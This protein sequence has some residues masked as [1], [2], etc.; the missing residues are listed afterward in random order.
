M[1]ELRLMIKSY[2]AQCANENLDLS[3]EF[4]QLYVIKYEVDEGKA[5]AVQQELKGVKEQIDLICMKRNVIMERGIK[6]RTLELDTA[7]IY[8]SDIHIQQCCKE[9]LM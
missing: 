9:L 6:L 3:K 7:T 4:H 8:R 2:K 1:A 5:E